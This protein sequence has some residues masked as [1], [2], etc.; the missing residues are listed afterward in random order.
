MNRIVFLM[1]LMV[2]SSLLM[3]AQETTEQTS[4]IVNRSTIPQTVDGEQYYFHAVLRGQTLYSIARAYGVDEEVIID[5]NPDIRDGLRYDQIIRIPVTEETYVAPEKVRELPEEAAPA[6][7]GDYVEHEVKRH[8]T[9]F[10]LSRKY[11]VSQETILF[12]NP[13]ARDVLRVGQILR[14]PLPEDEALPRGYQLYTVAPGETRFGISRRFGIT[15]D[16]LL[17]LNPEIEDGLR[18]GQELIVPAEEVAHEDPEPAPPGGYIFLPPEPPVTRAPDIDPY[19]LNPVTKETY[20]VALLIPLYLEEVDFPEDI[21]QNMI[22]EPV[23][24]QFDTTG[25]LVRPVS[26][27]PAF[28]Q[29]PPGHKAFSF[30]SYYHG[31]LIALD[32]IRQ[33]GGNFTLHVFDVCQDINKA[34]R[35]TGEAGFSEMDLIIGPFHRQ[36]LNHVAAF[37][38]QQG[39]PVVSPLLSERDQLRGFDN[40]FK[41]TPSLEEMLQQVS[42]HVAQRYPGQNILLVHNG[43]PGAAPIIREFKDS[44]LTR[45]ARVNHHYDSLHLSRVNG[46]YFD[47]TLVGNRRTNVL[48]MPG[49][50]TQQHIAGQATGARVLPRPNNVREVIY[51]NVGMQGLIPMLRRDKNNVLITLIGGE[52]FLSD[53]LR[54]LHELRHDYHITIFGIPQW[55]DYASIEI[56]YLQNLR[57]HYFTPDFYDYTDP[58]IR[59]FVLR[60]RELFR[61]EPDHDAIKGARTAYFFLQALHEFGTGF[62]QCMPLLNRQGHHSPFDFGRPF[63]QAGGWENRHTFIYRI[64]NYQTVDVN[65]PVEITTATP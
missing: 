3:F 34:R 24:P 12:Y 47:G 17:R 64:Q 50:S 14:I 13:Q 25:A 49:G 44:L 26:R 48:V 41:A 28:P 21:M 46:Y 40:L 35:V 30:L 33:Q 6:L 10:G 15:E 32:S 45:V 53:Y 9:L 31:V 56:N 22:N 5:A 54:Q 57:V 18:A 7:D 8:E 16:E 62:Q 58:H 59:D 23:V 29:L 11:G 37:A 2:C 42:G 19:C 1:I 52:P 55:Q 63:G 27:R 38:R 60:Y 61:T 43:Q 36:S 20:R 65:K 39:I 51:R 4:T